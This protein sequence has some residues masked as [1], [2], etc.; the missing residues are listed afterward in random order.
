MARS[1][2]ETCTLNVHIVERA[3][4][5][6]RF[7]PFYKRTWQWQAE[8]IGPN[9]INVAAFSDTFKAYGGNQS[10][11]VPED[12]GE[13]MVLKKAVVAQLLRDGWRPTDNRDLGQG[14]VREIEQ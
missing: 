6:Q 7:N 5:V 12:S 3:S 8:A 14:F 13:C 9:G 1:L 4:L 11:P 2:V 10:I